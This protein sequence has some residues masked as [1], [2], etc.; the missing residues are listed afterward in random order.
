[1]RTGVIRN[2]DSH[3]NRREGAVA[4]PRPD[5]LF[6]QPASPGDVGAELKRFAAAG[7]ELLVI[8]G[9]DGTVREVLGA[10]PAAFGDRIPLL[11]VVASGKTNILAFD[12]GVRGSWSL[13]AVLAADGQGRVRTRSPLEV[14][15]QGSGEPPMRGFVFG[16]AGLVRGTALAAGLHRARVFHNISVGL[17]IAG[18]V[19]QFL[20][21][22]DTWRRGEPLSLSVDDAPARTGARLISMATT[23]ERLPFGMRP[24][25]PARHGLKFLDVDAPPR[26]L[27]RALPTLL[28]GRG[29]GWLASRGYR[30][31]D[32]RRLRISLEGSF[33]LDGEV[34]PGGE[35]TVTEGPP[36]RFLTP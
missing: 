10:L 13:D 16:A 20:R 1:M 32:A 28:W 29:E 34:Y 6:A 15:R 14:R 4:P 24:F 23:L 12:L 19:G 5:L 8:D 3:A 9:G 30:R 21:G 2:P 22:D 33:V 26:A 18:A 11:S 25:G 36:L 31:G 35:L 17:T 7:V 27:A